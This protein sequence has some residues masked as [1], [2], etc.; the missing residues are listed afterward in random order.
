MRRTATGWGRRRW[1]TQQ[2][3][4][5]GL[6]STMAE[7]QTLVKDLPELIKVAAGAEGHVHQVDGHD[8]LIEA[9][10]ILGFAGLGVNIGV[11]KLRQ[12]MQV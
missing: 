7:G 3:L 2:A 1:G 6:Q 9:A 12:P 8:A 11:R 4:V 5:A 10:I